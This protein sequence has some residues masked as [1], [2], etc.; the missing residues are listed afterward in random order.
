M[1]RERPPPAAEY[2]SALKQQSGGD[3]GVHGSIR[4]AQSLLRAGLV[5]ELRLVI[6]PAIAGRGRRLFEDGTLRRLELLDV[7]RSATGILLLSY[8]TSSPA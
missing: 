7:E 6:S 8:R 1:W 4:L 2:V 3:I 5:D